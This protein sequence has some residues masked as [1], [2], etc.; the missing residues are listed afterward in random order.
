MTCMIIINNSYVKYRLHN[1]VSFHHREGHL[2]VVKYLV[3]QGA[4]ISA[5]NKYSRTPM[6]IA[7]R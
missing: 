5:K 2:N 6:D 7:R 4:N 1:Y 3:D